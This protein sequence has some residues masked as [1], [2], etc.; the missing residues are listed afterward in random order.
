MTFT[1]IS[2]LRYNLTFQVRACRVGRCHFG[3]RGVSI[4]GQSV[5]RAIMY[6]LLLIAAALIL[7]ILLTVGIVAVVLTTKRRK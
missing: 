5:D 1:R 7:L 2:S 4:S 3:R 6:L